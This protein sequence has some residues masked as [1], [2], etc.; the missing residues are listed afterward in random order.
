MNSLLHIINAA[1]SADFISPFKIQL[2]AGTVEIFPTNYYLHEK[3]VSP[4]PQNMPNN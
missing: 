1:S 4:I 3:A 2:L